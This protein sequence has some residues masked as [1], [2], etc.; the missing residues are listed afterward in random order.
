M[1]TR[2]EH[3]RTLYRNGA[4]LTTI[5]RTFNLTQTEVESI[6][7][8]TVLT[9]TPPPV[10]VTVTITPDAT[11]RAIPDNVII[12]T[13]PAPIGVRGDKIKWED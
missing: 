11:Q 1:A 7:D 10:T 13:S 8:A 9:F 5:R 12:W 2:N 3:I 4:S 6:C